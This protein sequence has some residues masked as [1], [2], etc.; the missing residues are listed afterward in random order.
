M[1]AACLRLHRSTSDL[2]CHKNRKRNRRLAR[3]VD[4]KEDY[5]DKAPLAEQ[6]A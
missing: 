5:N 3:G 6:L 2:I 1:A 4:E